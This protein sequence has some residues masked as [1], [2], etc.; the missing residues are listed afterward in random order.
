MVLVVLRWCVFNPPK[1]A[2]VHR[3][4]DGPTA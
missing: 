2:L 3:D 1:T 4:M